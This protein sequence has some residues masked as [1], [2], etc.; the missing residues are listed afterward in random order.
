MAGNE[1]GDRSLLV[2][3]VR[4]R[5]RYEGQQR[6][7]HG[8]MRGWRPTA[9]MFYPAPETF[10][11]IRDQYFRTYEGELLAVGENPPEYDNKALDA[12]FGKGEYANQESRFSQVHK[13]FVKWAFDIPE[14]YGWRYPC[15][16]F[17]CGF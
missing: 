12:V 8:D 13:D 11:S 4:G 6:P 16:L 1:A 5:P 3:Y 14:G 9:Q 10:P 17:P 7:L 2:L 15:Q